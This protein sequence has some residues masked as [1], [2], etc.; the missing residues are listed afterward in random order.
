M[1]E[2]HEPGH[3]DEAKRRDRAAS[4]VRREDQLEQWNRISEA[5]LKWP[6]RAIPVVRGDEGALGDECCNGQ[7]KPAIASTREGAPPDVDDGGQKRDGDG[8]V[9]SPKS[10]RRWRKP[11]SSHVLR[12]PRTPCRVL[13]VIG[14]ARLERATSCL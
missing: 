9:G 10:P 13:A 6:K 14:G 5:H 1:R 4:R 2:Q 3:R 7:A 12:M 8:T 11:L